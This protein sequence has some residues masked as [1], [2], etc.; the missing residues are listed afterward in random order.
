[1]KGIIFLRNPPE[2]FSFIRMRQ[3]FHWSS[4]HIYAAVSNEI[5]QPCKIHLIG[6]EWLLIVIFFSW[7][8]ETVHVNSNNVKKI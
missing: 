3:G 1:M 7:S 6:Y 4:R 8:I 5:C 2:G